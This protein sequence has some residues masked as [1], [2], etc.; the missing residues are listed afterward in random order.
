M[1]AMVRAEHQLA[2]LRRSGDPAEQ[3]EL[4]YTLQAAHREWTERLAA[5]PFPTEWTD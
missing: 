3:A 5:L 4:I 2:L 1:V